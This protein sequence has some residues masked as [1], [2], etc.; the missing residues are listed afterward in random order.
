MRHLKEI[1]CAYCLVCQPLLRDTVPAAYHSFVAV[2]QENDE[3]A[4]SS[5][6]GLSAADELVKDALCIV[7]E[8]TEL[9]LPTHQ[10]VRVTL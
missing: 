1:L 8:V 10:C 9:R 6:L 4:L 3:S 7:S 2:R 5:P